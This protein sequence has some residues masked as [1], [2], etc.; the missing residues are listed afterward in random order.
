MNNFILKIAE[1]IVMYKIFTRFFILSICLCSLSVFSCCV[2]RKTLTET[3]HI[4]TKNI[5]LTFD[6]GPTDS[7]TPKVLNVLKNYKIKATFFVIGNQIPTRADILE[8]I[9]KEGHTIGIH[10]QSHV[11]AQIY[12]SVSALKNDISACKNEINRVLPDYNITLYRFPGGSFN[13]S[14]NLKNVPKE[15]GLKY[16]DWNADTNDSIN[17]QATPEQLYTSAITTGCDRQTI[18]LL[19]HDGVNYDNTVSALP[20]IIEYYVQKNYTFKTLSEF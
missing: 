14:D 20:S 8:R 4:Y 5:Y 15:Y 18:I 6:D 9:Y 3:D 1:T 2:K 19:M 17:R 7:T 11:Y 13:L 10:T 12:K 16:F